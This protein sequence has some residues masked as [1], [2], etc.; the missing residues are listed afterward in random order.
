[1]GDS[2]KAFGK[3]MDAEVDEFDY[4]GDVYKS[5]GNIIDLTNQHMTDITSEFFKTLN[6]KALDN[7]INK[8]EVA[9]RRYEVFKET[10]RQVSEQYNE[11]LE[12]V[13]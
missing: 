11:M 9:R 13:S 7:N 3:K 6:S 1:M 5:F 10:F 12:R 2:I 8:I 4:Y